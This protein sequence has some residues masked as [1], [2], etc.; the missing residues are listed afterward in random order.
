[1]KM[2]LVRVRR[3]LKSMWPYRG[4]NRSSSLWSWRCLSLISW[5]RVKVSV[6]R[7]RARRGTGECAWSDILW[8]D[9]SRPQACRGL[10]LV[11]VILD[12]KTALRVK[13]SHLSPLTATEKNSKYIEY[14][15]AITAIKVQWKTCLNFALYNNKMPRASTCSRGPVPPQKKV[16]VSCILSSSLF[17]SNSMTLTWEAAR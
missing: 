10:E 5:K 17:N 1:M 6:E 2:W 16:A 9:A 11:Q 15:E 7:R 3:I 12:K 8:T 13:K 14:S 4:K